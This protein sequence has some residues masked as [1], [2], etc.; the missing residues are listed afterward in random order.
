MTNP[1]DQYLETLRHGQEAI[2]GAVRTWS[3][4]VQ[5]LASAMPSIT[6][7]APTP[8]EV[9]DSTFNFT[10]QVL[11]NQRNFAK[12]LLEAFTPAVDAAQSVAP[13]VTSENGTSESGIVV[14]SSFKG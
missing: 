10:Q 5:K 6:G 1:Q 7:D 11:E 14:E 2:V 12:S 4:S 8:A 9:V 3:E 13:R